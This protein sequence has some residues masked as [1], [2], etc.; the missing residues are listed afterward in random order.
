MQNQTLTLI[1]TRTQHSHQITVIDGAITAT[2]LRRIKTSADDMGLL[3]Y[4]PGLANTASC[5][6]SITEV[7]RFQG[8]MRYRGYPVQELVQHSTYL[9][10]AYL[11]VYG[12]LPTASQLQQ[13]QADIQAESIVHENMQRFLQGFLY[14]AHPMSVLSASV[15]ALST[16][17]HDARQVDSTAVDRHV[18]RLIAKVPTLATMAYRHM[19]G[20]PVAYPDARLSFAGNVLSMLFKRTELTYTPDPVAEKALNTLFILHADHAQN[21]STATMRIVGSSLADPYTAMSAAMAALFGQRHGG[22][23]EAVLYMLRNLESPANIPAFLQRVKTGKERV[24]GFGHRIYRT[25]DPRARVLKNLA[26]EIAE[27]R[28][29]RDLLDLALSLEEAA[30]ADAYFHDRALYPNVDYYAGVVYHML[31]IPANMFTAMFASA[32]TAGWLAHWREKLHDPDQ[33]IARPRQIYIGPEQ[34]DYVPMAQRH[35]Q[36]SFS[37]SVVAPAEGSLQVTRDDTTFSLP[38][39]EGAVP[40]PAWRQIKVQGTE[41]IVVYDPAFANTAICRSSIT[42]VD[43]KEGAMRYRGYP[44]EQMVRYSTYLE[45]AYLLIHG[46]LPT[47]EAYDQWTQSILSQS[48]VHEKVRGFLGGFRHDAHPMGILVGT[49]AGLSAFYPEARNIN[50]PEIVSAQVQRLIA[51]MPTL[52]AFA[53]RHA[54]GFPYIYPRPELGYV[55]NFL[56]MMFARS[57]YDRPAP[58]QLTRALEKLFILQADHEQATSTTTMRTVG[59]ALANPY[60]CVAAAASALHGPR[61]GGAAEL[62]LQTFREIGDVKNVP[63]FIEKVK[64]GERLLM[65]FGHRIYKNYDPRAA[66]VKEIAHE[67]FAV[68]GTNP[69]L[70][71]ALELERIALNDEYFSKRRLYPNIDLYTGCIYEA[72]GIPPQMFSV[73]FAIGRTAG[74]LAQW[75]EML[76]DADQRLVHPHQIYEG[77]DERPYVPIEQ[78]S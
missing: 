42:F 31:G 76:A 69:M 40:A 48:M 24:A 34:R 11:L 54:R 26:Q 4:D 27:E 56:S 23:G 9:E 59:S 74:W 47:A 32:R 20:R 3:S 45:T 16:F 72:I 36:P 63:A 15:A 6:S 38:I 37:P 77:P 62:A 68:T 10:V 53:Y 52:A 75:L 58:P 17:Y 41:G 7:D 64:G 78:R 29:Q 66:A 21:C 5:R 67:V 28:G 43:G 8:L 50:D 61:H 44:I 12:E 2:D 46:E 55:G 30:L 51:Q 19:A 60:S 25:Y 33:R 35:G 70:D 22:A 57:Q 49:L 1:D 65:G 14:D 39:R 18:R 73:M 13:W 71:I